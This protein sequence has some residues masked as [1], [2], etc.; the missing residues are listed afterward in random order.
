MFSI[1]HCH[2]GPSAHPE[3]N[4]IAP[5]GERGLGRWHGHSCPWVT[6]RSAC[7]TKA[8]R[9]PAHRERMAA[10][11]HGILY[12]SSSQV[13]SVAN[14]TMECSGPNPNRV[15]ETSLGRLAPGLVKIMVG[16]ALNGR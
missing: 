13:E 11:F 7:A 16:Q 14:P 8:H 12:T 2:F 10:Y 3:P 4:T 6:G 5:A 1:A 9:I 15:K